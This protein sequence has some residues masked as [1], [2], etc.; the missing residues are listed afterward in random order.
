MKLLLLSLITFSVQ[1]AETYKPF[2][3]LKTDNYFAHHVLI[4]E[5][6]TH[7]LHLFQTENDEIKLLKTY[8]IATG[9]KSGDK[10]K[11]GDFKTP[12]GIYF[13]NSFMSKQQLLSK[14]GNEAKIY[15]AG[16]FFTNYPNEIDQIFNKKGSGIWLHS[17]NDETRIEKGLDSRGCT[18]MVNNDLKEV[19]KYIELNKTPYIIT[20]R[21]DWLNNDSYKSSQEEIVNFVNSWKDAWTNKNLEQYLSHYD[22][23]QFKDVKGDFNKYKAYK[24]N[25]FSMPGTPK[26]EIEHL[27]ILQ[28]K[29]YA[30]VIFIQ[31]YQS[32]GLTDLGKK[33]LYLVRDESDNWKV[34]RE[35]W[36]AEGIDEH[37]KVAFEPKANFFH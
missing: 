11:E 28:E 25:V 16:A 34:I 23:K 6:S 26:V 10:F 21:L 4:A 29:T 7:Q 8:Q 19:S 30:K 9:K 36:S 31:K 5:K 1:A 22:Q 18:V 13:F 37:Q 27:T 33:E 3:I 20:Q 14:I 24:T 15:G 12:E 17:T 2:N 35:V 32:Q